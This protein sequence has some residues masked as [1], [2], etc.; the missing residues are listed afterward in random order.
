MRASVRGDLM[1]LAVA[2][3]SPTWRLWDSGS[4]NRQQQMK[5][6]RMKY[7]T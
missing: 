3:A 2:L 4:I 7:T 6:T 5:E 1:Q